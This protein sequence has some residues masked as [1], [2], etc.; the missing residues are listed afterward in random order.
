M[1]AVTSA[2][3]AYIATQVIL[4]DQFDIAIDCFFLQVR[5]ALTSSSTFSR[6]DHATDSQRFYNSVVNFLED[7]EE[8]SEVSDLLTFWNR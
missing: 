7:P 8:A 5:F 1:K 6:S 2:S 3:I 4:I